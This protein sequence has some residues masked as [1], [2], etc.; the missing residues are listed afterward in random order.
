MDFVPLTTANHAQFADLFRREKQFVRA[1]QQAQMVEWSFHCQPFARPEQPVLELAIEE[2]QVLGCMGAIPQ[3]LLDGQRE[4]RGA[5][6]VDWLVDSKQRRR[7][8]GSQLILRAC[9][10]FAVSV[11]LGSTPAGYATCATLGARDCGRTI[12]ARRILKAWNW[13][14]GTR[15]GNLLQRLGWVAGQMARSLT[16]PRLK[17]PAGTT[18]RPV[19]SLDIDRQLSDLSH[20]LAQDHFCTL[21]NGQRWHWLLEQSPLYQGKAYEVSWKGEVIGYAATV[22]GKRSGRNIGTVADICV[23]QIEQ[24]APVLNAALGHLAAQG[25]DG[26]SYTISEAISDQVL[27]QLGFQQQSNPMMGAWLQPGYD[28]LLT[29]PWF[30]TGGENLSVTAGIDW[31]LERSVYSILS[32]MAD[33]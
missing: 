15:K 21:R 19:A 30:M 8:V 31:P 27:N 5:F 25:V 13:S 12:T 28:Y 17:L 16:L 4:I 29:R 2:G 22:I 10:R 33:N 11:H 24:A 9:E 32:D 23:G 26:L 6:F 3:I 14:K 18:I 20:Q 1:H 7:N